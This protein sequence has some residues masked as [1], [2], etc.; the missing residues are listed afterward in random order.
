MIDCHPSTYPQTRQ[1]P[2][3][4]SVNCQRRRVLRRHL[5]LQLIQILTIPTT[6]KPNPTIQT[7]QSQSIVTRDVTVCPGRSKVQY[8]G[9]LY[10]S[11]I[12]EG[13]NV[14]RNI[15]WLGG[16]LDNVPTFGVDHY[17]PCVNGHYCNGLPF[18]N[19][20]GIPRLLHYATCG[21]ILAFLYALL[22][23]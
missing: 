7:T 3:R 1:R 16:M 13:G 8:R 6:A 21:I 19:Y 10:V 15:L 14:I 4:A 11:V 2:T 18:S 20:Y 23:L 12:I 5:I 22:I 9:M 17:L